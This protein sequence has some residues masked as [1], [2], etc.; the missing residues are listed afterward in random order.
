M[1]VKDNTGIVSL[2]M[3]SKILEVETSINDLT[4][5]SGKDDK[6]DAEDIMFLATEHLKL[7]VK[8]DSILYDNE[9][10]EQIPV[11]SIIEYYSGKFVVLV[12][13]E[14]DSFFIMDPSDGKNKKLTRKEFIENIKPEAIFFKKEYFLKDDEIEKDGFSIRWLISGFLKHKIE[15]SQVFGAA[16]IIQ[17]FALITPFFTMIIIDKVFTSS[18]TSTLEV[19]IIGLFIIAIFE[20]FI[21]FSRKYVLGIV[22]SK[23]EV[24]FSTK[25][26]KHIMSLPISFYSNKQSG[27]ISSRFKEVD[28]IKNFISTSALTAVVDLPFAII[29]LIVM[30]MFSSILASIVLVAII[31]IF[32]LY[33]VVSPALKDRLKEKQKHTVEANSFLIE[34]INGMET[35]KSMS[36][37]PKIFREYQRLTSEQSMHAMKT[38]RLSDNITTIGSFINKATVALCLWIGAVYVLGSYM[39]VGQLIAFNMLVGRIMAPVQRVASML[40]QIYQVKI[41]TKRVA[42]IFDTKIEP[43]LYSQKSNLPKLNGKIKLSN[44]SFAYQQDLPNVLD[45]IDLELEENDVIGI[46]GVSGSGKTTLMRILQR[47]HT[48]TSG[49]VYIDDINIAKIDPTWLRHNMGVVMQDN[50]LF[51]RSIKENISLSAPNVTMDMIEEA[52]RLSGADVFVRRLPKAYDT[53]VGERGM[54]ISAGERQRIA[55]ARAL[56]NDSKI[57][58]LDEATSALDYESEQIIH[59]NMSKICKNK[60]VFIVSHRA[61]ALTITNKIIVLDKGKIIEQGATKDLLKNKKSFFYKIANKH[62]IK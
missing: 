27:D 16:L 49:H 37:E 45:S 20:I 17:L 7:K 24:L 26:F 52:S 57:L 2:V 34:I 22:S 50:L 54:L 35:I 60:T 39:T 53:V 33:F 25:L 42:E 10:I 23:V 21:S 46:V 32:V 56:I 29:F 1:F 30:Y 11:P 18:G 62:N 58:I 4:H 61:S 5:K 13:E 31:F 8:K 38:E 28:F 19:L 47:L 36:I 43:A 55:I 59:D 48:P 51:N 40:G 12:K 41:S 6:V 44:V 15:M 14:D 9:I 3:I